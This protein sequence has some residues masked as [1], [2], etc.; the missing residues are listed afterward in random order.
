MKKLGVFTVL[1]SP[2]ILY[3]AFVVV[4][5]TRNRQNVSLGL[6][7]TVLFVGT[8]ALSVIY[9]TVWLIYHRFKK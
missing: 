6:A 9:L 7:M 1:Y 4:E 5:H 2:S 8:V 3:L